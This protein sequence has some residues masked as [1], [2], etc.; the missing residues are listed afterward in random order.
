MYIIQVNPTDSHTEPQYALGEL[1]AGDGGKVYQYAQANGAVSAG[2]ACVLASGGEQ[3]A[4]MTTTNSNAN[5]VGIAVVAV[6]DDDHAWFQ[7]YGKAR[8]E[9]ANSV[10]ANTQLHTTGTAGRLDDA[11]ANIINGCRS[12]QASASAGQV[13]DCYISWPHT[14]A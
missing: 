4:E 8:I 7:R 6:A 10:T 12:E 11:T 13:I 9:V 3:A 1:G 5:V 14:V 2:A